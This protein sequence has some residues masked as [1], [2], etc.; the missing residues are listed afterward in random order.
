MINVKINS[1]LYLFIVAAIFKFIL[2]LQNEIYLSAGDEIGYIYYASYQFWD[3]PYLPIRPPILSLWM[4]FSNSI[5]IRFRILQEIIFIFSVAFSSFV[6][7]KLKINMKVIFTYY[8]LI[9]FSPILT[10][11]LDFAMAD[12][13]YAIQHIIFVSLCLLAFHYTEK[14][15]FYTVLIFTGILAALM[16]HT[17]SEIEVMILSI[18]LF[19]AILFFSKRID[20]KIKIIG[21]FF[22]LAPIILVTLLILHNNYKSYGYFGLTNIF[23]KNAL[24]VMKQLIRIDKGSDHPYVPITEH[25]REEAYV[26]S[27]TLK[28]YESVVE[29]EK[30]LKYSKEYTGIEG[31]IDTQ[32]YV[33]IFSDIMPVTSCWF[34][35]TDKSPDIIQKVKLKESELEKIALELKEGL[36]KGKGNSRISFFPSLI[37]P[38]YGQ[39]IFGSFES[40][41]KNF[42]MF[43]KAPEPW[44]DNFGYWM[45]TTEKNR[46]NEILNRNTQLLKKGPMYGIIKSNNTNIKQ[47]KNIYLF[48]DNNKNPFFSSCNLRN[49]YIEGSLIYNEKENTATFSFPEMDERW[50]LLNLGIKVTMLNDEERYLGVLSLGNNIELPGDPSITFKINKFDLNLNTYQ[51]I[52]YATQSYLAKIYPYLLFT[53][54]GLWFFISALKYK[55]IFKLLNTNVFFRS[56][57]LFLSLIFIF[58]FSLVVLVDL[59]AWSSNIRYIVPIY[60]IFILMVFMTFSLL[61]DKKSY[62]TKSKTKE[63]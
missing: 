14:Y 26:L 57:I 62:D 60:P 21:F 10:Y 41:F 4:D 8:M 12:G 54:V 5:G 48:V 56:S 53:I 2:V 13:F 16:I 33:G 55:K 37:N 46:F 44:V 24:D 22:F 9:L 42:M 34:S 29:N 6:L 20:L 49:E 3:T 47:I 45:P 7:M 50:I 43:F 35:D 32:R 17:K 30:Y 1:I 15:K 52:S 31:S 36:D 11:H 28:K 19:F 58:K 40:I 25:A 18:V 38:E 61:L 39:W 23:T 59:A 51:K 27:P 63:G